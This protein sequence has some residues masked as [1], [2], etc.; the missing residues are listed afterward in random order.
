MP[1]RAPAPVQRAAS[2][3]ARAG[4]GLR[5][6]WVDAR[7]GQRPLLVVLVVS[8]ILGVVML[9]GP[10]ERYADGRTRVE[11]MRVTAAALDEE[12]ARLER[13]AEH[14][15]DP[16]ELERLAR[17][18]QGMIRPGEV[19]YTLVPPE[20][21]RPVISA[22]RGSETDQLTAPWYARAWDTVR[23]WF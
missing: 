19:P 20:V 1:R 15:S 9:S 7:S 21:D 14:L 17:E 13:R 3:V 23:G 11:A 16:A 18:E 22:P 8:I 4:H 5:G 12:N 6:L 10:F 2:G